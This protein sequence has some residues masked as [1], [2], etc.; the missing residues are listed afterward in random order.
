MPPVSH[1]HPLCPCS[2]TLLAMQGARCY[3]AVPLGLTQ[4]MTNSKNLDSHLASCS[5]GPKKPSG[6]E[7]SA[8]RGI[9]ALDPHFPAPTLRGL[10]GPGFHTRL[11]Y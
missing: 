4:S 3:C 9:S 8:F 1:S 5:H 7:H 6:G 11:S 10:C 2:I